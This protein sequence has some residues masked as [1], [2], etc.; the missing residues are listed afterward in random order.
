MDV[1]SISFSGSRQPVKH[2]IPLGRRL[3][4]SCGHV[5]ND[6]CASMWFSYLLIFEHSVLNLSNFVAG[7]LMLLGQIADGISTPFVGFESDQPNDMFLCRK[8]GRRK[9]WH[10]VGTICVIFSFPFLFMDCISCSNSF[11][12]AKFIYYGAFIII[13]QFGWAST[14]ISH[15]SLIPDLTPL[16]CERVELNSYR[17]AMTVASNICVYT[18]LLIVLGVASG[19]DSHIGPTD[20]HIFRN[21]ALAMVGVGTVFSLIFHLFVKEEDHPHFAIE[22]QCVINEA[23]NMIEKPHLTWSDWFFQPQF[24]MVAILY[25]STR[26]FFNIS[27]VYMPMYIQDT[28]KLHKSKIAIIPLVIFLSGF[29]SSFIVKFI[30]RHFGSKI[31]Y[32]IGC[33]LGLGAC[34]WIH[35]GE[36]ETYCQYELYGVAVLIGVAGSTLLI[37]SL[38]ITSDLIAN[39]TTSGAFVFGCMS[40]L[41]K[42]S[43]GVAVELIQV[44]HPCLTCCTSCRWYYRYILEFA[45]GGAILLGLISLACLATQSIGE[46]RNEEQLHRNSI[47]RHNRRVASMTSAKERSFEERRSL[48]DDESDSV[49][50]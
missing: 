9:A 23:S 36:G 22:Q 45:C 42:L 21:V 15:L 1:A 39:S 7:S 6:L 38:G 33:I 43:N 26:L 18:T 29:L 10:L 48:L 41:D 30:N 20:L 27:Q 3:A 35:F 31:T 2:V 37:M 11:E 24:Y 47:I 4:Y 19:E 16:S 49:T 5:L 14:Q 13:F 44:F 28:L 25:T 40:F 46:R 12:Y 34:V 17:Y 8:Y 32:L 50:T